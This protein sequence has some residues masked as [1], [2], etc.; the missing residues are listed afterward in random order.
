MGD[1]LAMRAKYMLERGFY[2]GNDNPYTP[3]P[4]D[5]FTVYRVSEKEHAIIDR[6]DWRD[7]EVTV[8]TSSL[9]NPYFPLTDWYAQRVGKLRGLDSEFVR[10]WIQGLDGGKLTM[11][12][13]VATRAEQLADY[14]WLNCFE[15]LCQLDGTYEIRDRVRAFNTVVLVNLLLNEKF[16]LAQWYEKRLHGAHDELCD[17]LMGNTQEANMLRLLDRGPLSPVECQLEEVA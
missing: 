17:Q 10:Q 6:E 2:P 3:I 8:P 7:P 11:D 5:W 4:L 14:G 15:C 13:P 1:P 9:L 12:T 16:Q